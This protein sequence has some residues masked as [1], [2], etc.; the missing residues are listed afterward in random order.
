MTALLFDRGYD[1]RHQFAVKHGGFIDGSVFGD[2]IPELIQNILTELLMAHFTTAEA[3]YYLDLIAVPQKSDGVLHLGLEIVGLDTA[4]KLNFL[5][6]D[7]VL[8]LL[9]FFFSLL[10]LETVF[11]EVDDLAYRGLCVGRNKHQVKSLIV[12]NA[13]S[14]LGTHDP[15]LVSGGPYDSDFFEADVFVKQCF[16]SG[17][18]S[19]TSKKIKNDTE[20]LR[21]D[22]I[23]PSG[24]VDINA[25]SPC[26][27][28]RTERSSCFR[29]ILYH[30]F[31]ALSR[32]FSIF[33]VIFI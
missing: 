21:A 24:C 33:F 11:A 6:L 16:F 22:T 27:R 18:G 4:G 3:Q 7:H 19:L 5:D 17:Y 8:F 15:E 23:H 29:R 1:H 12:R 25:C 20:K 26:G 9:C 13:K 32:V 31:P 30:C 2:G 28:V 14:G 10:L